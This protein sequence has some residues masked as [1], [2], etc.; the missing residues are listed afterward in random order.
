M[1]N[2]YIGTYV[3]L[4]HCSHVGTI[5]PRAEQLIYTYFGY[6][7]ISPCREYTTND[8]GGKDRKILLVNIKQTKRR[9]VPQA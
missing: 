5:R 7:N 1:G 6:Q 8:V 4:K 3:Y 2:N 9:A